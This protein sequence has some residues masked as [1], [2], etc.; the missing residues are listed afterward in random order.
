MNILLINHYAGSPEMGMEFRPYYF[1]REWVKMGHK[2]DIIAADYSHLRRKNPQIEKDFQN[3]VIDGINY[4]WIKTNTYEGNGVKRAVTMAQFVGKLWFKSKK[5]IRELEPDVVICSSTY[6]ID[7][8]VRQRIRKLSKK[9]VKLIHEVHDMWPATLVE[10]GGMSRYNPFVVAMQIGENSAY[11]RS[12]FVISLAEYTEEYMKDHGLKEGRF[13]CVPLGIDLQEWEEVKELSKTHRTLLEELKRKDKF[14]VG[15][16]GGHAMSNA[17]DYL[18]E[19]AKEINKK[20][21]GIHFVLVGEGV[22]KSRLVDMT[23]ESGISNVT[24]L[25]PIPKTEIPSLLKLF[26]C[27]YMGT[28]KNS[29]YRFGMC[30]NKML[31]S[32]MSGKPLICSISAPPTW[33]EKSGCGIIVESQNIQEIVNAIDRIYTMSVEKRAEMGKKGREYARRGFDVRVLAQQVI[34]INYRI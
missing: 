5:I 12:D 31:D 29:L 17:L 13:E 2:V 3:E 10:L 33:A 11:R 6:P 34:D 27:I 16:F 1:A 20:N 14:I 9:K 32:M 28:H 21:D 25:P 7:T 22:E 18:I 26:D 19:A 4:H 30:L 15:Y 23:Y 24:F 8:F